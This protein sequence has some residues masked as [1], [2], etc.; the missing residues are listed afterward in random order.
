MI[1]MHEENKKSFL[2]ELQSLGEATK[3]KV[4]VVATAILMI[5]V[6]YLWLGYFN[7][8]VAGG[9]A[10]PTQVADGDVGGQAQIAQQNPSDTTGAN[11]ANGD[12]SFAQNFKNGMSAIGGDFAG[13]GQAFVGAFESPGKYNIQPQQPQSQAQQQ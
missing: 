9:S 7:G 11:T 8:L 12:P 4:V 2:D 3:K 13:M 6:V 1:T 10:Q 5:G